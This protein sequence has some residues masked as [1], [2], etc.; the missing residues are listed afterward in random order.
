MTN[1][2]ID[3][4][5]A[6]MKKLKGK[7]LEELNIYNR[8]LATKGAIGLMIEENI[9][10]Y[11]VGGL[12]IPDIEHLGIEIKVTPVIKKKTG[13][14][15]KERLVLNI[16]NYC[17]ENWDDF[18]K[19]SLWK[20]NQNLLITFYESIGGDEKSNFKILGSIIYSFPEIDLQIIHNDWKK[21]ALKVKNGKAHELSESDG[22]YL[23]AC[24][25]GA[26]SSSV[27]NQ[28]YSI[29]S[30]KQRAYSLKQSYMTSVFRN[31][32]LGLKTD[33]KIIRD[34]GILKEMT[35]EEYIIEQFSS[36]FGLT[37]TELIEK[38]G[39]VNNAN[40]KAI[41]SLIIQRILDIEIGV[42][43]TDE[44]RKASIMPKTIR[45]EHNGMI[46]EHM[47]FP[48]FRFTEIIKQTWS[49]SDLLTLLTETRF[50]FIVFKKESIDEDYKL[51]KILFWSMPEQDI[52]ECKKVWQNTVKR[53]EEG[54]ITLQDGDIV[55]TNLP[56]VGDNKVMHVRPHARN[57]DDTYELPDGR[58]LTKQCFWINKDYIL[59]IVKSK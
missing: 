12:K 16:I 26:S 11:N 44:F 51:K 20:K 56:K 7:T 29:I 57:R 34:I 53:I 47:S 39:L 25:K 27:R 10:G 31:Y 15:S 1:F 2:T 32:V 22:I 58:T 9:L 52:D 6:K 42:E 50:M 30:A 46:N 28:P 8:E 35:L 5:K 45:V 54:I 3:D 33:P 13:Y 48:T 17:E 55:R 41:N 19:T 38:L 14:V 4:L 24:T 43:K 40:S 49:D 37:Q 23:G 36:Y 18:E 21:I 59:D